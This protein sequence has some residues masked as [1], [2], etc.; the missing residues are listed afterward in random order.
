MLGFREVPRLLTTNARVAGRF[1]DEPLL[2]QLAPGA[3]ADLIAVDCAPPTPIDDASWFGHLAYGASEAT[4]RH[5]VARGRVVL[6]DFAHTTLRPA[7]LAAE[8][9]YLAPGL[10]QRF[11]ELEWSTPY[12]GAPAGNGKENLR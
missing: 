6:E 11:R 1:L 8:A 4:V 2:G 12:L 9:R 7:E 5:T 3:P 10:W